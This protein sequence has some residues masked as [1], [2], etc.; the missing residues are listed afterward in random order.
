MNIAV[1]SCTTYAGKME[2]DLQLCSALRACGHTA[3]IAAWD[4][5]SV[6]WKAF[7]GVVL[8][9]A[10]NYQHHM[11]AFMQWLDM[12][13]AAGLPMANTSAMVRDNIHKN[14]QFWAMRQAGIPSIP[15]ALLSAGG[16]HPGTTAAAPTLAQALQQHFSGQ[17]GP[18]VLKPIISASGDNTLLFHTGGDK[19]GQGLSAAEP[20][21]ARLLAGKDSLGVI[22]QPF[23]PEIADGEH[24]LVYLGGQFSHCALR[25]PGVLQGKQAFQ[26]AVPPPP[27][28]ALGGRAI[29]AQPAVPAYARVDV[30]QTQSGPLLMELELAEPYLF[31]ETVP[32]G[33]RRNAAF[34]HFA[35]AV[36]HQLKAQ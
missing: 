8:R 20:L 16:Q 28:L 32:E 19:P 27:V 33:A 30:V 17:K 11:P 14:L 13:D 18:F 5:P 25:F 24:A 1:T 35:Q 3:E 9:S 34:A 10:W 23:V 7:S 2:E 36:L 15:S 4:D 21:Y 6:S 31:F 12:L 26:A 22:L 29:A